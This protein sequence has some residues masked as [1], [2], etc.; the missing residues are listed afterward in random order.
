LFAGGRI[1]G[2]QLCEVLKNGRCSR[3]CPLQTVSVA[4]EMASSFDDTWLQSNAVVEPPTAPEEFDV[5]LDDIQR[6]INYTKSSQPKPRLV[7]VQNFVW[8]CEHSS[9]GDVESKIFPATTMFARDDDHSVREAVASQVS[10]VINYLRGNALWGGSCFSTFWQICVALLTEKDAQI[11]V[12]CEDNVASVAAC[13]AD[14]VVL[15]SIIMPSLLAMLQEDEDAVCTALRLM[16]EI[17]LH[18]PSQWVCDTVW[19]VLSEQ[20][21]ASLPSPLCRITTHPPTILQLYHSLAVQK[22]QFQG[23]S[24]RRGA[25]R[26][27]QHRLR[28]RVH[29]RTHHALLRYA[30]KGNSSRQAICFVT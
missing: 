9:L 2:R 19:P 28:C 6:F 8:L 27:S 24:R 12:V 15:Q 16:A 23:P 13:L 30:L 29:R 11:R 1:G 22:R 18:T 7:A 3:L 5:D 21:G 4:E 14:P 26:Q 20:V 17:A 25:Y 10:A